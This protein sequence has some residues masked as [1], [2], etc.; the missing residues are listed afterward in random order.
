[1][2]SSLA[3]VIGD[4]LDPLGH[5][6][7]PDLSPCH[8]YAYRLDVAELAGRIK[9]G[10]TSRDVRERVDE[11]VS[12]AGL[13]NFV[14]ILMNESAVTKGGRPFTDKEVH[15][16]LKQMPGVRHLTDVGGEELFECSLDDVRSAYHSVY[17]GVV[18]KR[19]RSQSFRPRDE[20]LSAIWAANS[21]FD[22]CDPSG[23]PPRYLWNAKMRFGK[24]FAAYHLAMQ[25]NARR[26][27]VVTYKP[28]VQDSWKV[29]LETHVDFEGW[30]FFSRESSFDPR[31]VSSDTPLVCFSSLH[32]LRGRD[33]DGA[34]KKHNA[35]IHEIT[36][37]L[38]VVDEYHYG[39]WN[40]ATRE[41]FKGESDEGLAEIAD[42]RGDDLESESTQDLVQRLNNIKGRA[43]LC[44]S[45]TPFRAI[46][47]HDFSD[48]QI[49]NWTYT[50]E[51]RAKQQHSLEHPSE[52]NPY[53]ALPAMNLLVYELPERLKSVALKGDRNEFDLNEF[54]S[55][56][57]RD[58][59]ASFSH[60]DQVQG[61][62]EWL[63][64]D[65]LGAVLDAFSAGTAKP[66][67]YADTNVLA[68]MNHSVWFLPNV[69]AVF[70]M[71]NLL[72]EPQN[73]PYWGQYKVLPVAG[74][75]AGI[76]ARA[77]PPVRDAIRG[78]F[79]TKS[80]TLTCGKLLTGVT[81]PQW[82]AILMLTNL[83]APESYFQAAF[84]VQSPWS[85]WNP[86][87]DDPNREQ[88]IKPAC[89]VLDFAPT[90][91][92]RLFADYG[93]RLGEGIDAD[94]DVRELA[95]FLPVLGF[96]GT[97]MR[98]ISVDEIVDTAFASSSVDARYMDRSKFIDADP[99]K[100]NLL[101]D[102]A[103]VA[104]YLVPTEGRRQISLD[105]FSVEVT[106]TSVL[107]DFASTSPQDDPTP[108]EAESVEVDW[109]DNDVAERLKRLASRINIF[110]YLSDVVEKNLRQVLTTD[111]LVLFHAVMGLESEHMVSLVRAGLFNEQAMRLAIHQFRR[112]DE[113]AHR[114]YNAWLEPDRDD[115]TAGIG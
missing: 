67:P 6:P 96:D 70:A 47:S 56:K 101:T 46:A 57:G 32:D 75:R 113:E 95:K 111:E 2:S 3:D 44:L 99:R 86:E 41:L 89:L 107:S 71:R 79:D 24:T 53:G 43:F 20:Q 31:S 103:R 58:S 14:T 64:G 92:L 110:M 42:A 12:T 93:M 73:L 36:W 4:E 34:I 1:M 62:L 80:I 25:R 39:A 78:G 40:A 65:D 102:E 17:E 8:I 97:R 18:F 10:M 49:Y 106:D 100:L 112:A 74:S 59:R 27:L 108:G 61:W 94:R 115:P 35:W 60:K 16:V 37:D 21:Y 45:G 104:L 63:R 87:G 7:H 98:Y 109:T 11:Q 84:R 51:Q 29:D 82:S 13:A 91:S 114:Y 105:P 38:V 23:E 26:V 52:W 28:A 68:Y 88:V 69:A 22:S 55:A 48:A 76:G 33:D 83:Q 77:L 30:V 54:F 90:R 66:F 15:A 81:V 85:R 5:L 50:N 9:V 72:A 19:V